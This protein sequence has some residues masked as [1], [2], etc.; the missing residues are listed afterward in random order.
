MPPYRTGNQSLGRDR[1]N[2]RASI[3]LEACRDEIVLVEVLAN[4]VAEIGLK[5]RRFQ[6]HTSA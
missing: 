1:W 5:N 2:Q 3:G 6:F 4:C